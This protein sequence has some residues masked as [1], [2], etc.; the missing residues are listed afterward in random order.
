MCLYYGFKGIQTE[1]MICSNG[2]WNITQTLSWPKDRSRSE[3]VEKDHI[4]ALN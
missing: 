2:G 3:N 1:P 4:W